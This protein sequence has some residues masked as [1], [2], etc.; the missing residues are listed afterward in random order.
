MEKV[1]NKVINHVSVLPGCS[2]LVDKV[3][4][5]DWMYVKVHPTLCLRVLRTQV[6]ANIVEGTGRDCS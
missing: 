6:A 3:R 2:F 4:G 1:L 5:L